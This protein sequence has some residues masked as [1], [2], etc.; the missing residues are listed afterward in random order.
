MPENLFEYV[1]PDSK[2]PMS[3]LLKIDYDDYSKT[4]HVIGRGIQAIPFV[5]VKTGMRVALSIVTYQ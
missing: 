2:I 5:R 1:A 3:V 4:R